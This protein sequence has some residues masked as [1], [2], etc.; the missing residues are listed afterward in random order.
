LS[1]AVKVPLGSLPSSSV[2]FPQKFEAVL[3][4][5]TMRVVIAGGGTGGHV[6]PALAL[7]DQLKMMVPRCEIQ[8][9]G[10]RGGLEE[11]L[12]PARGYPLHLLEIG[13][14]RGANTLSRA[15]TMLG[16]P[17]AGL[18]A[19]TLL[20]RWRPHV[21]V[22]VGGYASGPLAVAAALLRFPMVLM[23]QNAVPGTTNR[24]LSH[25]ADRIVVGFRQAA[26]HF[27]ADRTLLLGNPVRAELL[28][29]I[30]KAR[31]SRASARPGPCLLVLG[32]SQGAHAINELLVAAAPMLMSQLPG[33]RV[34]HQTGLA[35]R[36]WVQT[37][38][39]G[40]GLVARVEPFIEEMGEVYG[41][42][43][44]VVG[45]SGATTLAELCLA[46]LPALLIPYPHA[47]DDHQAE[48]ATELVEAGGALMM[49]QEQLSSAALAAKLIPLLADGLA[50]ERMGQAMRACAYPEAAAATVQVL[51]DLANRAKRSHP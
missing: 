22:G 13:K 27:P 50:L 35:D 17:A 1:V 41:Q 2:A 42:A 14:L 26:R 25:L 3:E 24:L 6:F 12:V 16:L 29:Q 18:A 10:S 34:I 11:R 44:L 31:N 23:E 30:T 40:L 32:G 33:L 45:R 43:D 7:A 48:N 19:L 21:V 20:R 4:K 37:Q 39:Q 5:R 38:Y 9:V 51:L 8:F 46:G 36:E 47:A 49:R 28:G 15:R